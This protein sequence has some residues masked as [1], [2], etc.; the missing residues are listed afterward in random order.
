MATSWGIDPLKDANGVVTIGTTASD[1]RKIQGALYSP[2]LISGG[3]VSL[4][5]SAMTYTVSPGVAAFPIVTSGS[6]ETVLGPIPSATLTTTAAP[7]GTT[8][9]DVVYA[10]QRLVSVEGDP[11]IVVEI[12]TTLPARAV[13]LDS[14]IVSDNTANTS[15]VVRNASVTYSLPYGA[16]RGT[17]WFS[18]RSPYN[19]T[20]NA[21]KLAPASGSFYLPSDRRVSCKLSTS[22]SSSGAV[23]FDNSKYCEAAYALYLN[24][25]WQFTWTTGGLHQAMQDISWE[26]SLNLL[27]GTYTVRVDR[28]KSA[29]AGTPYQRYGQGNLGL[30]FEIR[31]VGPVA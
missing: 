13:L 17:P 26:E 6:V 31:D 19:G 23:G 12:G 9:V 4:S 18:H 2:G 24:D 30:L 20:F 5:T 22:V 11:N 29:G 25:V 15:T 27:K 21:T 10:R 14:F 16:P 28:W 8:R 1:F 3:T 7:T